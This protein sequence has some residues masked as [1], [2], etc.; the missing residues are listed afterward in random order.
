[1]PIEKLLLN[2]QKFLLVCWPQLNQIMERLDWDDNPYFIDHWIQANWELLVEQQ[3]GGS[4]MLPAYGYDASS[5]A[6]YTCKEITPSHYIACESN[7]THGLLG[8]VCFTT[9]SGDGFSLSPPFDTVCV[10]SVETNEMSYLPLD[11]VRFS[12]VHL[13]QAAK[14]AGKEI[15]KSSRKR[16]KKL[17]KNLSDNSR[18]NN[19]LSQGKTDQL[20]R[21]VEK[22]GGKLRNDGASGVKGSSAGKSHVQTE[23]LGKSID[24]RH[25]WTK[26]DVQ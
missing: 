11:T 7:S 13:I 26:E 1:M 14:G 19:G 6:R 9:K 12:L 8:F 3:L 23:G 25:V 20:R 24:S 16:V 4:V 2:F 18:Q 5:N 17:V 21:I 15:T 10:K 22:A